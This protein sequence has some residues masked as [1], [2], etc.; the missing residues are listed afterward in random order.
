MICIVICSETTFQGHCKRVV[1]DKLI[2]ELVEAETVNELRKRAD[3]TY[4]SWCAANQK[5][6]TGTW[7]YLRGEL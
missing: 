6:F 3:I 7:Y 4:K 1:I 2:F 5:N